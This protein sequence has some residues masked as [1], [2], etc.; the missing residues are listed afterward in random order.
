MSGPKTV[1]AADQSCLASKTLFL[2][3]NLH[4]VHRAHPTV[5]WYELPK[6]IRENRERFLAVNDGY[7]F[8]SCGE[9]F[10]RHFPAR[11]VAHPL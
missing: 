4:V 7:L 3:N 11:K 6:L 8:R 1:S 5:P 10:R 9:V 2:H